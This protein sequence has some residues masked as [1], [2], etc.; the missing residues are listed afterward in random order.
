ML[1]ICIADD[2]PGLSQQQLHSAGA[3]GL[4]FD[5]S[6][7][8]SGLGLC[9][10]QQIAQSYGGTLT[11]DKSPALKGLQACLVLGGLVVSR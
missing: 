7:E 9:I 1:H 11:L 6:V 8:G 10:T 3:R 2:G 4:R 5:E